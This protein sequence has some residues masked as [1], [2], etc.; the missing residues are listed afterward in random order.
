LNI[1]NGDANAGA[2]Y[3][4]GADASTDRALGSL[5]SGSH[6]MNFGF[7]LRNDSP[8]LRITALAINFTQELWRSAQI[9]NTVAAHFGTTASGVGANYLP[10]AAA[11]FTAVPALNLTAPAA[12]ASAALNGNANQTSKSFTIT[13][14][15]VGPG[16]SFYLKWIDLDDGGTDGG[17]AI[18]DFSMAVSAVPEA[19]PF[20]FGGALCGVLGLWRLRRNRCLAEARI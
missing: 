20:L 12:G 6:M 18:D 9:A 3:N 15:N 7:A 10:T 11:G 8:T 5:A 2:M 14:L 19:S 4:F 13:G 1:N 17:L 16:E